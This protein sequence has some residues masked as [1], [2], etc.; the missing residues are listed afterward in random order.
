MSDIRPMTV[1]ECQAKAAECRD[2]AEH[3][4]RLEHRAM[5]RNFADVWEQLCEEVK[6]AERTGPDVR[7]NSQPPRK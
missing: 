2:M 6:K 7:L 4:P 5:L 3:A 1:E